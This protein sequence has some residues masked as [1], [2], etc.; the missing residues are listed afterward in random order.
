MELRAVLGLE[1][2]PTK[3]LRCHF[4]VSLRRSNQV[5]EAVRASLARPNIVK[6]L[7][8]LSI[9]NSDEENIGGLNRN[10]NLTVLA[11]VIAGRPAQADGACPKQSSPIRSISWLEQCEA[12]WIV[13]RSNDEVVRI[14]KSRSLHS[15]TWDDLLTHTRV[16]AMTS[17]ALVGH[18]FLFC[19]A[20]CANC[21]PNQTA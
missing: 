4:A 6:A 19:L 15:A 5:A 17:A 7:K 11:D 18:K 8:I 9:C 1:S 14:P 12:S 21:W 3:G 2:Q 20:P 10:C 16:C 13:G